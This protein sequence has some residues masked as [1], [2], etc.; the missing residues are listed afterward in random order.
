MGMTNDGTQAPP[1]LRAGFPLRE[2]PQPGLADP[3]LGRAGQGPVGVRGDGAVAHG[4]RAPGAR[5][6]RAHR[7]HHP[8]GRA[9]GAGGRADGRGVPARVLG[10]GLHGRADPVHAPQRLRHARL[11][12]PHHGPGRRALRPAQSRDGRAEGL[13]AAERLRAHPRAPARHQVPG[14]L[15]ADPDHAGGRDRPRSP[16]QDPVRGPLR[17]RGGPAPAAAPVRRDAPAPHRAGGGPGRPQG[18]DP[19]RQRALLRLH[20]GEGLGRDGPGGALLDQARPDRQG[21]HR[22]ERAL[23]EAAG[24][25]ADPVPPRESPPEPGRHRGRA[26]PDAQ[27]RAPARP[28][29]GLH[30]RELGAREDEGLRGLRRSRRRSCAASRSSSRISPR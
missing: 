10:A 24:E 5:A 28:R 1:G 14:G 8:A 13:P 15:P 18:P 27:L 26:H 29:A 19:A 23:R 3:L 16:L 4:T 17:G 9:R 30:L 11:R 12:Q 6:A 25:A 7:R 20:G 21:V 2:P 22:L